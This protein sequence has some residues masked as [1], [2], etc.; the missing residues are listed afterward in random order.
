MSGVGGGS[1]TEIVPRDL[2]RCMVCRRIVTSRRIQLFGCCKCGSRKVADFGALLVEDIPEIEEDY[3]WDVLLKGFHDGQLSQ[4]LL[5]AAP[6]TG[7]SE[8][9]TYR[10]LDEARFHSR[11]LASGIQ[12]LDRGERRALV[13]TREVLG[14]PIPRRYWDP[15]KWNDLLRSFR[16]AQ[17]RGHSLEG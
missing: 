13:R 11:R 6:C 12:E 10:A 1:I 14:L 8:R 5:A 15:R 16:K 2:S 7:T 4:G 9:G 17:A 3:G